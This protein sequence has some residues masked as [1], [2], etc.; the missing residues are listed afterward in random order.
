[1][2]S[3]VHPHDE[4]YWCTLFLKLYTHLL[5]PPCHG[6]CAVSFVHLAHTAEEIHAHPG[7]EDRMSDGEREPQPR[8]FA[9]KRVVAAAIHL[10]MVCVAPAWGDETT[11]PCR[12]CTE[13]NVFSIASSHLHGRQGL[14]F[15]ITRHCKHPQTVTHVMT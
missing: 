1:M 14:T 6:G 11:R 7:P 8:S 12:T 4:F 9:C 13:Q 3:P 15:L 10:D 5:L 2:D